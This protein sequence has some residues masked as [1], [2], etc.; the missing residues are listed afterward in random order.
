MA[1]PAASSEWPEYFPPDCP[2]AMAPDVNAE[3]YRFVK[4]D[5]AAAVRHVELA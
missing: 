2:A 1:Q 5:S 3:V 4:N